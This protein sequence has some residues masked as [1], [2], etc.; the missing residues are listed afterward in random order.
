M[1]NSE[2]K[3]NLQI[4]LFDLFNPSENKA[5]QN[6]AVRIPK[7]TSC[8]GTNSRCNLLVYKSHFWIFRIERRSARLAAFFSGG[9]GAAAARRGAGLAPTEWR[10]LPSRRS[11]KFQRRSVI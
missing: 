9:G 4:K 11:P 7:R 2:M 1:K 8:R 10:P 3:S 6:K 5:F